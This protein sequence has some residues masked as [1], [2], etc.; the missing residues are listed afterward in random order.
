M[1]AKGIT[2]AEECHVINLLV[3]FDV[4]AGATESDYFSLKNYAH[5]TIIIQTGSITNDT[6]FK[7]YESKDKAGA[8]KQFMA[9]EYYT[10]T[11]VGGGDSL[12]TR[13]TLAVGGFQTGTEDD[14]YFVI[15][16]DASEL[17]D[18]YQYLALLTDAPGNAL[19]SAV[20]ILSGSRYAGDP[21]MTRPSALD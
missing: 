9:A 16:I 7:V 1:S 10:E 2:I 19:L 13:T 8:V 17:S 5:A 20:A 6:L 4:V 12:S 18:G 21:S 3:P 15:E 11:T 14:S